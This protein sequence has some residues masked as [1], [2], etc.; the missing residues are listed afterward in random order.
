M[1]ARCVL[2]MG[3]LKIFETTATFPELCNGLLFVAA[4]VPEIIAGSQKFEE[5]LDT[6]TLPFLQNC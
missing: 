5:S 4:S 6:P 2:Y 3:A 1:T